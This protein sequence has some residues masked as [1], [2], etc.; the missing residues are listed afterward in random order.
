MSQTQT[1]RSLY[2]EN[3]FAAK[4]MREEAIK[5][6]KKKMMMAARKIPKTRLKKKRINV[7]VGKINQSIYGGVFR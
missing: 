7:N 5:K 1:S 2:V 3:L 4:R 6:K